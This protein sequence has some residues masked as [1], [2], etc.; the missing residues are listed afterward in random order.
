MADFLVISLFQFF[1]HFPGFHE[2]VTGYF[3]FKGD[4]FAIKD[5]H[6]KAVKVGFY[7]NVIAFDFFDDIIVHF[8]PTMRQGDE[9]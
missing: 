2:G 5:A 4:E 7:S 6:D 9:K 1:N 3:G 8:F